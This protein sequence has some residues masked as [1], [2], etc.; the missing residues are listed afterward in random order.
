MGTGLPSEVMKVLRTQT[1]VMV[2]QLYRMY[3]TSLD[4]PL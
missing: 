1:V 3:Y 2:A 4:G